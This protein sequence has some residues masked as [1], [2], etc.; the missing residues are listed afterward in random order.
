MLSVTML[1][2][3]KYFA[4]RS[5]FCSY[6]FENSPDTNGSIAFSLVIFHRFV[7]LRDQFFPRR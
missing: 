1:Y 2:C 3:K 6:C 5:P 7:C 4:E